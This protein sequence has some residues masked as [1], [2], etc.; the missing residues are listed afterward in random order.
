MKDFSGKDL[1]KLVQLIEKSIDPNARVE[2]DI[3]MP[4]LNSRIGATTQCDIVIRTGTPPRETIT[5]FEIQDRNYQV[6]PNDFRGWLQKLDDVGA[7]HLI[8][9]SRKEFPESIKEQA[10]LSGNKVHLIKISSL[11]TDLIPLE[12]LN[13]QQSYRDFNLLSIGEIKVYFY[14][15]SENEKSEIDA[16]NSTVINV[17][18]PIFSFNMKDR[19]TI[20]QMCRNAIITDEEY[21]NGKNT[22]RLNFNNE[23]NLYIHINNDY[24]LIAFEID[25]EWENR[26]TKIPY[27][28]L[29]YEQDSQHILAWIIEAFYESPKGNVWIKIPL[30]KHEERYLP[31]DVMANLPPGLELQLIF[32]NQ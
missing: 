26:I 8:C 22:L 21:S 10:V 17:N 25:F 19:I 13:L 18:E 11:E 5:I 4:I 20:Y 9:V 14:I 29:A 1:E 3:Q 30:K 6:K 27:S 32:S 16:F 15:N 12:I 31:V 28:V 2:R 24:H 23:Q 7:Q